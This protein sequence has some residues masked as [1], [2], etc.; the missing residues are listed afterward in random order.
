[1]NQLYLHISTL[2]DG[3][4]TAENGSFTVLHVRSN[5]ASDDTYYCTRGN[6]DIKKF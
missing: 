1:M 3:I 2:C 4:D 5:K 6:I